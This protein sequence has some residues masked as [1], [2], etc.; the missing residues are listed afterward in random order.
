MTC[1]TERRQ[2]YLLTSPCHLKP[3]KYIHLGPQQASIRSNGFEK[4][5]KPMNLKI[6][7]KYIKEVED[8]ISYNSSSTLGHAESMIADILKVL[9]EG[10]T[11]TIE[12]ENT[13]LKTIEDF[14]NWKRGKKYLSAL[15]TDNLIRSI[16][17][18][19]YIVSKHDIEQIEN[20]IHHNAST[21]V[22]AAETTLF[23]ILR[24][25]IIA[26][27][28]FIQENGQTLRSLSDYDKWI[29]G[30]VFEN[31]DSTTLMEIMRKNG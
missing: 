28:V 7:L 24:N 18:S 31:Y 29:K 25:L 6:Q 15:N 4:L 9:I 14:K 11:V 5:S 3:T 2:W 19:V 10:G 20:S 23:R 16:T 17:K 12:G 13:E 26:E 27:P 1:K 21:T 22:K 30:K 8:A